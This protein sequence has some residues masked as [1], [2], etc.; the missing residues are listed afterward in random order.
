MNPAGKSNRPL[1]RHLFFLICGINK[2]TNLLVPCFTLYGIAVCLR[3]HLQCMGPSIN[4]VDNFSKFFIPLYHIGSFL[5]L[6]VG[7][8]DEFLT[9]HPLPIANVIYGRPYVCKMIHVSVYLKPNFCSF[10]VEQYGYCIIVWGTI[11]FMAKKK[12]RIIMW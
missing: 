3:K 4:N 8:F 9:L 7:N 11:Y 12:C 10:F 5:V 1:W 2:Q 6:S